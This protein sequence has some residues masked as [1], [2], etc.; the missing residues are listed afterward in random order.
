[1]RFIF[2]MSGRQTRSNSVTDTSMKRRKSDSH[3][4]KFSLEDV[5]SLIQQSEDRIISK[6]E[7]VVSRIERLEKR[8]DN[9]QTEQ[10]RLDLEV[11]VIKKVVQNQQRV[12]EQFE[13]D[14]RQ[15][16]LIFSG[17]PEEDIQ[18]NGQRL[19]N[20]KEKIEYLCRA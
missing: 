2:K 19:D 14:K 7:D 6:L 15:T 8:I 1:M 3:E 9:V 10:I 4:I 18:I 16:N 5:R 17:V 20:D 12:I 13:A 11:N